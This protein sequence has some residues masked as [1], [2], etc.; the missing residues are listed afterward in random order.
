MQ[1][2]NTSIILLF[3]MLCCMNV[4]AQKAGNKAPYVSCIGKQ[5]SVQWLLYTDIRGGQIKDFINRPNFPQSPDRIE[6]ITSLETIQNFTDNYGSLVRGFIQAPETGDYVFNLTGDDQSQLFLSTDESKDNLVKIAEVGRWTKK[7]QH[8]K[9]STQTSNQIRLVAG[10]FYYFEALMKEGGGGDHVNVYWKIPSKKNGA[11]N[12]I[13]GQYLFEDLCQPIC[14]PA[15]TACD[16]NDPNTINDQADGYCNCFGTP[17]NPTSTCIGSKGEL[18][19]LYWDNLSGY[20]IADLEK[21]ASYPLKPDR[22]EVLPKFQGPSSR[23]NRY[24]SKVSGF[25]YIPVD[26]T[27]QFNITGDDHVEFY[28]SPDA[29]EA[30]KELVANIYGWTRPTEFTKYETQTT[31]EM[32][33][34]GGQ[35]HYVELIHKEHHGGDHFI[36]HWKNPFSDTDSWQVI[37]GTFL[38]G[39]ACEMACVP[40]G[41]PCD[42]GNSLTK[43][44]VYD[45]NCNCIGTPCPNGDCS[46]S[47][48]YEPTE[49]CN[50]TDKHTNYETESWMSCTPIP[51][52]NPTRGNGHWIMYDF[53]KTFA[54]T[55]TKIWNYNVRGNTNIGFDEVIID[56]S[57][58]GVNWINLGTYNWEQASG[59]M[60]YEGFDFAPLS[61]LSTRYLLITGVTNHGALGCY[62][63]SE[64]IFDAYQC[65]DPTI[66]CLNVMNIA[67]NTPDST[68]A[69]S[70]PLQ[71]PDLNIDVKN[72]SISEAF[73]VYPNPT[74]SWTNIQFKLSTPDQIKLGV[75][76]TS[77]QLIQWIINDKYYDSEVVQ[78]SFPAQ[79]LSPGIYLVNLYTS[80]GIKSE[81]LIVLD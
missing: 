32:E 48:N 26:G 55:G 59:E 4:T 17:T 22:A 57:M 9:Y 64:I 5:G 51:S 74:S 49:E 47:N 20:K 45:D 28:L 66:P 33:L 23:S 39:N 25:L 21:D 78:K 12:I 38:F 42:D 37:E 34:K 50:A 1:N 68:E 60:E 58:D 30:N 15:G 13:Q 10:N 80:E 31:A 56:Y 71:Q 8:N 27:Y 53:G 62:G 54:I 77:G 14:A 29:E 61:N 18:T 67:S 3:I 79:Q 6:T 41:T 63:F 16:D 46:E 11:W 73:S 19:V 81:K 70:E 43:N 65:P 36:V 2:I 40:A 69:I 52:P 35:F 44:D 76:N 24:G 72:V 75:F 7:D